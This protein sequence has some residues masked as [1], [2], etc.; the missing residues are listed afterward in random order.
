MIMDLP[1]KCLNSIIVNTTLYFMANLRREAGPF[2][3]FLLLAFTMMMSMSM[4]FRFFASITK[5]VD[6]ALAPSSLVLITMVLYA[7]FV[8]PVQYMRG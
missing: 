8:I 4:Y 3:F 5:S 7:G 6:Q 1:Y 2:F